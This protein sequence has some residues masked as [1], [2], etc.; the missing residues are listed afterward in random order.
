[1]SARVEHAFSGFGET[2]KK[3][4]LKQ[5]KHRQKQFAGIAVQTVERNGKD[6]LTHIAI[7][8][9][10]GELVIEA[11]KETGLS[12][13]DCLRA[14]F[15]LTKRDC[16]F[17]FGTAHAATK[18]FEG[19]G[20]GA[21]ELEKFYIFHPESRVIER[22]GKT[23]TPLFRYRGHGYGFDSSGYTVARGR[24][25]KR[26]KQTVR[27]WNIEA[28]TRRS[29]DVS[30]KNWGNQEERRQPQRSGASDC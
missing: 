30:L 10:S 9:E 13:A 3:C 17:G 26:W 25:E 24:T 15:K 1:M 4:G 22:D 23:F 12:H 18:L 8:R 29:F 5:S 27:V 6:L 20:D 7:V 2:C 16:V 11:H 28:M 14:L 19:V 21:G